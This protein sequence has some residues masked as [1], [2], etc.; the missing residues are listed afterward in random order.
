MLPCHAIAPLRLTLDRQG[1]LATAIR[2]TADLMSGRT[3]SLGQIPWNIR[4]WDEAPSAAWFQQADVGM[5]RVVGALCNFA[6]SAS[7]YD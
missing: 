2:P 3:A 1:H 7:V 6:M 4:F 5:S